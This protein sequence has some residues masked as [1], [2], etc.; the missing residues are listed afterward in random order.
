MGCTTLKMDSRLRGNDAYMS[1][2]SWLQLD[3]GLSGRLDPL[4]WTKF[5]ST[6]VKFENC[7]SGWGRATGAG[8]IGG[9]R[10]LG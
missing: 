9:D 3:L 1:Y 4:G 5:L 6:D 7:I 10:S 2:G 8:L